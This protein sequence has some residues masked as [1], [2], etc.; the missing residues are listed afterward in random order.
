MWDLLVC[1]HEFFDFISKVKASIRVLLVPGKSKR[2][3]PIKNKLQH[4]GNTHIFPEIFPSIINFNEYIQQGV[5]L[6]SS[7][8]KMVVFQDTT[9]IE[10]SF[11][12]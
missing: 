8:E 6:S 3:F 9:T 1:I 10:N 4:S 5:Y 7:I 2:F 11:S 12:E